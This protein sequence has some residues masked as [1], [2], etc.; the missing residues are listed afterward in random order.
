MTKKKSIKKTLLIGMIGLAA[1][2]TILSG[3]TNGIMMYND[4]ISNMNV[5]LSESSTA[6]CQSVQ[7]SIQTYR[8]KIE[9]IAQNYSITDTNK[10]A[11][12]RNATLS[13]LAK[14]YG[15][16]TLS[17]SD[18]N[19]HTSDGG[20]V[21]QREYFKQSMAG[22]TYISSTLVSSVTKKTVL[23]VSAKINNGGYDGIVIATLDSDTFSKMVDGIS[24][25]QSGYGFIV[26]KD[27]KIIANKNRSTVTS[28]TNYIE[29]AKKDKSFTKE[30]SVIQN[31]IAG[32]TGVQSCDFNGT[33]QT[34]SYTKIPD[35]D[36]WSIGVAAKS[37]EMMGNFYTSIIIT[38]GLVI[39]FILLSFLIAFRIAK[40][41]VNPIVSLVKRIEKLSDGDLHSEVPQIN[42]DNEIGVL[43]KSFTNTV[44]TLNN[45]VG[46]ISSVLVSLEQGDYTITTKQNYQGDFATIKDSLNAIITNLNTIFLKFQ[47]STQQ[48]AGGAD[49]VSSASQALAQGA[50]EQASSIQELSASITEIAEKVKKNAANAENA[51]N[52]SQQSSTEL[53][54][55]NEQMQ[56]MVSAMAD[57]SEA[58]SQIAKIIKTIEDIA[59]QTNILSLNAAVEAARAGDAGKGFAVVA[60]EVRSLANKSA[61]AAK[62]TTSLIENAIHAVENGQRIADETAKSLNNVIDVATKTSELIQQISNASTEQAASINQITTG[63]D[64]ISAVVQTNSATSEQSAATSEELSSQA[65]MLNNA[66]EAFK[67]KGTSSVTSQSVEN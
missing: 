44:T 31:M 42:T 62:N 37:S 67:L 26:D 3:V 1:S 14:Q 27:G 40:P 21:I 35:T 20:N 60:D 5:R 58:S 49:Q 38:I 16:A 56:T 9:A 54:C 19:G 4:A 64:Q 50:T 46:E 11:D 23:I 55:G 24:I 61:E 2:V 39:L 48:V 18:E 8:T 28:Q 36:G 15:F 6:Y 43:S 13:S 25:G 22:K 45:Y 10:T 63:V 12:Q 32:K 41:I 7:N 47:Q 59:F 66:L 34:I 53:A 30:A 65:Q 29:N 57:I 33:N 51:N 52:L 17:V